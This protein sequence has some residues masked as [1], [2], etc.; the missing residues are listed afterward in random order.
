LIFKPKININYISLSLSENSAELLVNPEDSVYESLDPKF[1]TF[2]RS[3]HKRVRRKTV[4]DYNFRIAPPNPTTLC[5]PSVC[6]CTKWLGSDEYYFAQETGNSRLF[7]SGQPLTFE[8]SIY[9]NGNETFL[10]D[11]IV[12]IRNDSF[13]VSVLDVSDFEN[14]NTAYLRIKVL[15]GN[16]QNSKVYSFFLTD[17]ANNSTRSNI[18]GDLYITPRSTN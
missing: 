17:I 15:N 16:E 11:T 6:P 18:H 10:R 14:L 9:S 13:K 5:R 4:L 12:K 7:F 2:L 3:S 1:T 8:L